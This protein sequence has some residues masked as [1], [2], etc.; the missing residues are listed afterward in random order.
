[1]LSPDSGNQTV[2]LLG[3]IS[4]QLAGSTDG[5][6][7]NPLVTQGPS[8]AIIFV[9]AMWL[10]SLVLSLTSALL[11]TLL[12]QWARRYIETPQV[13]SLASQRAR[14]RSFLF[15]GTQEYNMSL[16]VETAP[17][18]LHFSLFL[19]FAGL[20]LFFFTIHK[21]VAIAVSVSV[22]IFAVV[23]VTLTILP[24]LGDKCPYRTP[25]SNLCWY[26]WHTFLAFATSCCQKKRDYWARL[27]AGSE[28]TIIRG[29]L[30]ASVGVDRA[31]LI[32]LFEE[33]ALVGKS[34]LVKFVASIPKHEIVR[35]MTP[36]TDPG[37]KKVALGDQLTDVRDCL[38]DPAAG[39]LDENEH[40]RCV[41]V[42]LTA[43]HHI[44]ADFNN[45]KE[46]VPEKPLKDVRTT[47]A[48]VD[49]MRKLWGHS[50]AAIRVTS[51]QLRVACEMSLT[52]QKWH[53]SGRQNLAN[54]RHWNI[55][56]RIRPGRLQSWQV[57]LHRRFI[58][59]SRHLPTHR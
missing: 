36:P 48:D 2:Q 21:T 33:L 55:G 37:E 1:M 7:S 50:D 23:Y 34:E 14:V 41:L 26:P 5:T 54:G 17:T 38:I 39:G 3:Q 22:G 47:F 6:L 20:I 27:K 16:A 4:Q 29:A 56:V 45:R 30:E 8:I 49:H 31:A 11:A 25:M 18:L 57:G 46:N 42:W 43:F 9:N 13:P 19:F 59:C 10:M 32:Q 52:Q 28:N 15:S 44:A 40:K 53:E 35:I 12:Q 24:Y 51:L 58:L